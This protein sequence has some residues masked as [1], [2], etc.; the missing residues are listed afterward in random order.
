MRKVLLLVLAVSTIVLAPAVPAGSA[1]R[2]A[3]TH[4]VYR[5]YRAYFLREPD[6]AGLA[7][8]SERH[9]TCETPLAQI[10]ESFASSP[11]FRTRYGNLNNRQFVELV[12][13]NVLGRTGDP[14]GVNFWTARLDSG[15]ATRGE[16]MIGF[17]EST[18]F[19][20]KTNTAP[21][22]TAGYLCPPPVPVEPEPPAANCHASYPTV[23]I[24]PPP[25]DLSCSD[26]PYR[27]FPV[28]PPDPH[29]FDGN[30]D[31]IGCQS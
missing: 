17:S 14:T 25:P 4:S 29:G 30:K 10:S 20:K 2:A 7:F 13:K 5:L 1:E 18:E 27:R 26:I 15:S 11:E 8:W 21:P 24:P 31:G 23:C 22:S 3:E 12:Y 9:L 19:V 6:A 28:L 16:V